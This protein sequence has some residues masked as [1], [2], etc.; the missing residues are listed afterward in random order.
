VALDDS[1]VAAGGEG[2]VASHGE[3]GDGARELL[4]GKGGRSGVEKEKREALATFFS[5]G[6]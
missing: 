4:V 2:G 6:G 1:L 5:F 3:R